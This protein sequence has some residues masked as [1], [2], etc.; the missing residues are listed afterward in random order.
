MVW[1]ATLRE[2]IHGKKMQEAREGHSA[3]QLGKKHGVSA[4]YPTVLENGMWWRMMI[5]L[6]RDHNGQLYQ[7]R[8]RWFSRQKMTALALIGVYV[9]V[10]PQRE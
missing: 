1:T 6:D 2:T 3:Q 7:A 4:M 10:K 5:G 9:A 8:W